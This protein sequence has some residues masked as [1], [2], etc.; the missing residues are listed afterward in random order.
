MTP[1]MSAR[2]VAFA[3]RTTTIAGMLTRHWD[4]GERMTRTED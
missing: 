3:R 2:D 4:W 1:D